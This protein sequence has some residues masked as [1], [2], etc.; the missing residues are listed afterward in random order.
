MPCVS[1]GYDLTGITLGS[2]CPECGSVVRFGG[3]DL[4]G[5]G[6]AVTSLVLGILSIVGCFVYGLPAIIMGGLAIIFAQIAKSDI[7]SNKVSANSRGLATA[8]FVCGIIGTSLGVVYVG[9]FV[10]IIFMAMLP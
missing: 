1:C 3:P 5:S 6:K 10:I 2:R 4:P 8:G 7:R 9:F